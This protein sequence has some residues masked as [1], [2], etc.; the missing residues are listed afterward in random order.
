VRGLEIVGEDGAG[1][2]VFDPVHIGKLS[3]TELDPRL[4]LA[5][6]MDRLQDDLRGMPA[7]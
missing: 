5:D 1:Q 4:L 2:A 7:Q 6:A 3:A